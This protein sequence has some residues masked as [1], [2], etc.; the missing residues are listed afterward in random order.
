[1]LSYLGRS[2]DVSGEEINGGKKVGVR[3]VIRDGDEILKLAVGERV[4]GRLQPCAAELQALI[5]SMD[6]IQRRC[7][8]PAFVETDCYEVVKLV[9]EGEQCYAFAHDGVLVEKVRYLLMNVGLHSISYV[10]RSG[11]GATH[12]VATNVARLE[13][14]FIWF[15]VKCFD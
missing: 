12:A 7:W 9:N 2:V 3:A 13:G 10:P 5:T 11:N 14:S 6:E 15:G 1:M 8:S 4:T